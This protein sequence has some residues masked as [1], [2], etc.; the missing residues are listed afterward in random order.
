MTHA[1]DLGAIA[2][3]IIDSNRYMTLG[4]ADENGLP[5]VSPVW[6]APAEHREFFWV[7][8]PDARHS[9]N[10]AGRPQ[11]AIV[12]FDSHEVGGW[13]ALYMSAVAEELAGD[14][15]DDGIAIYSR[16]SQAQGLPAWTRDD[17]QSPARHRLYRATASEHFVL[18]PHDQRLPVSFE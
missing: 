2:R 11:V 13:R 10:L 9:R 8:A 3:S 18:D 17:V 1:Q 6:F 16:R 12:I 5:W 15:V 4:T 7:S 14:D